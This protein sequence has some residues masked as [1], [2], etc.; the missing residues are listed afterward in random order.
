MTDLE[1]HIETQ[2]LLLKE[3]KDVPE[4]DEEVPF[5]ENLIQKIVDWIYT[6][7]P[8][9]YDLVVLDLAADIYDQLL[10]EK[11]SQTS[12]LLNNTKQCL[13][14]FPIN[15]FIIKNNEFTLVFFEIEHF[16]NRLSYFF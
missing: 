1:I 7:L 11:H 9:H 16:L 13:K 2:I 14:V 5:D 15:F 6:K 8:P 12:M 10:K 3:Y 4:Y